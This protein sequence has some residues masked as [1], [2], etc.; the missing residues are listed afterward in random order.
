MKEAIAVAATIC[1]APKAGLISRNRHE[2]PAA[3]MSAQ[4]RY[5]PRGGLLTEAKPIAAIAAKKASCR[6]SVIII[7]AIW[8]IEAIWVQ[9]IPR[10]IISSPPHKPMESDAVRI[11]ASVSL[12]NEQM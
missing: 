12:Q 10:F 8:V 1:I 6:N 2:C 3:A 5:A 4:Y 9:N 11:R 7:P